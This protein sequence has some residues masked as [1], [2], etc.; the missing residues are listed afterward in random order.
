MAEI[1]ET[2]VDAAGLCQWRFVFWGGSRFGMTV[3][4]IQK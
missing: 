1:T 4:S 2:H 3:D